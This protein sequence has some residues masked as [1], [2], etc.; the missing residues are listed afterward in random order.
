MK[1]QPARVIAEVGSTQGGAN[2]QRIASS[3][4]EALF[5]ALE[6]AFFACIL[7]DD[8]D[9]VRFF[10]QAAEQLW[11]CRREEVLGQ[12]VLTTQLVPPQ[13]RAHYDGFIRENGTDNAWIAAGQARQLQ[14][15]RKDG[16]ALWACVTLLRLDFGQRPHYLILVTDET[17]EVEQSQRLMLQIKAFNCTRQPMALLDAKRR[18]IQVNPAYTSLFGYDAQDMLGHNPVSLLTGVEDTPEE[19][20]RQMALPWGREPILHDN[21]ASSKTGDNLWVRVMSTPIDDAGGPFKGYSLDVVHD[22]TEERRLRDLERDFL[23]ALTSNLSFIEQGNFLCQRLHEIAP[24]ILLSIMCIDEQSRLRLWAANGL[25]EVYLQAI[26]GL[27]IGA[28]VG[29]CGSAATSGE[30]SI[31]VDIEHSPLWKDYVDLALQHGLRACWSFPIK[32]RNGEVAGTFAFYSTQPR[33]PSPYHQRIVES[34]SHL[35]MLAIEQEKNRGLLEKLTY[36]DP[37]TGLPNQERLRR[38]IDDLLVQDTTTN[39]AILSLGLDRFR[40]INEGLGH[41]I[42]DQVLLEI[43]K[44]L[45]WRLK[46]LG[47]IS[48]TEADIFVIVVPGQDLNSVLRLVERL[49]ARLSRPIQADGHSLQ[50]SS[51]VGISLHPDQPGLDRETLLGEAKKAMYEAKSTNRGSY[52]FFSPEMNV[53][54]RDRLMLGTALRRALA[55]GGLRLAYQPQIR[56]SDGQLHGVEALARWTDPE[57]GPIPPDIFI[58][59]A[60]ETG[61]IE[62]LGRWALREA[63]RQMA[64]WREQR[65]VVPAVSVNLASPSFHDPALTEYVASLLREYDLAG[66]NLTI[67]ITESI[68]I[69]MTDDAHQVIDGL[70]ALGVGLSVDD[71]G[72]GHSSLFNLSLLPVTEVKIDRGFISKCLTD[73]GLKAMVVAVIELGKSLGINVV[74]EGVESQEQQDLL[75]QHDCPVVQG[76]AYSRPQEALELPVWLER[77]FPGGGGGGRKKPPP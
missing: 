23:Q 5:P 6:Q 50:L 29:S 28:D 46:S 2:M 22:I 36:F 59:L 66:E 43:A 21:T 35:A 71:F 65:V 70:R 8:N 42:G 55:E 58:Q 37:L 63:C 17:E 44:R 31:C 76:Y 53:R 68:S 12:S 40:D 51:S 48:R 20:A 4:G 41:S 3:I 14:L 27:V 33:V 54:A 67:E 57:L 10:N 32:L 47:L 69:M 45:Q 39:I 77:S 25:S 56:L 15:Y 26:E 24:D 30:P 52:R 64:A 13:L 72:T 49:Q 19:V 74:A 16:N 60:E 61:Q 34:C 38:Y 62:T 11:A 75:K 1:N 18:M 73:T 9:H 7:I